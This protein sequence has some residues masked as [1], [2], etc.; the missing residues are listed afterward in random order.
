[1]KQKNKLWK[2]QKTTTRKYKYLRLGSITRNHVVFEFSPEKE[3]K[4]FVGRDECRYCNTTINEKGK[5][6]LKK[7]V[8]ELT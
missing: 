1:M 7:F 8:K 3:L 2:T 6:M 4:I 5:D